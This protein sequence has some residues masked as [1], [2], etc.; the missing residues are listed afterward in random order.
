MAL[1]IRC[2][3]SPKGKVTLISKQ[4]VPYC[5][6]IWRGQQNKPSLQMAI[7]APDVTHNHENRDREER[8]A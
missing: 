2:H 7:L 3:V 5:P 8:A 6:Y 1:I 4:P